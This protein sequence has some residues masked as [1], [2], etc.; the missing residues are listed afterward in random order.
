MDSQDVARALTKDGG[1]A[2]A[3]AL[4]LDYNSNGRSRKI[5]KGGP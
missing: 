3:T 2:V 1:N 5:I 4:G